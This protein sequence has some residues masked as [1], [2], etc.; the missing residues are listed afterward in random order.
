MLE[1][2]TN[3]YI[4]D[5][6]EKQIVLE[7]NEGFLIL[8]YYTRFNPKYLRNVIRKLKKAANK[9]ANI[10]GGVLLTLT[11]DP[12][13]FTS[14]KSAYLTLRKCFN[15]FNTMVKYRL[16][17]PVKFISVL[18]TQKNGNPHLHVVYLGIKR[19]IDF[20][21]LRYYWDKK[22]GVGMHVDIRP[23]FNRQNGIRYVMKYLRKAMAIQAKKGQPPQAQNVDIPFVNMA[24]L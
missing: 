7:N 11:I 24:I 13:R 22:C 19:L 23:L 5:V 2:I 17:Q 18:E 21:E 6:K 12:K 9:T 4:S 14:L 16:N 1:T 3:E 20:Y 10:N 8:D 15:R